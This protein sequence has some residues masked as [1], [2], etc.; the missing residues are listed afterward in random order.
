MSLKFSSLVISISFLFIHMAAIN[1]SVN[2]FGFPIFLS[3]CCSCIV[4]FR[5]FRVGYMMLPLNF[6]YSS[7][8]ENSAKVIIVKSSLIVFLFFIKL[9]TMLVSRIVMI[10]FLFAFSL[11]L[12]I[13]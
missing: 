12:L 6:E 1:R 5:S 13:L 7:I 2:D 4:K 9:M 11:F 3:F 10:K 8:G